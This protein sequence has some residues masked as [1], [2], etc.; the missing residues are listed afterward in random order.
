[1]HRANE[2][3]IRERHVIPKIDDVLPELDGAKYFSKIDL[4]EGYHQIQ[5]KDSRD[6]T[7]FATHEGLFRYK[8]LIYGVSGAF[9]SFQKQI[10]IVISGCPG[11]KNISDDIMIWGSSSSSSHESTRSFRRSWSQSQ[12]GKVHFQSKSHCVCWS[13]AISRRYYSTE[14]QSRNYS[15]YEST[16]KCN[17]GTVIPRNGKFLQQIHQR[18]FNHHCAPAVAHQEKAKVSFGEV[19]NRMHSKLEKNGSL[20][21]R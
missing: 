4:R 8:C 16:I 10:E 13:L 21:P 17:R 14:E 15:K 12:P 1:M 3:I 19:H 18:L 9:E 5:L 7:T 6:I 11:S 20:V 2:A